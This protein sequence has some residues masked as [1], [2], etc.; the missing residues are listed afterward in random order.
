M[1]EAAAQ[2]AM[3]FNGRL[4]TVYRQDLSFFGIRERLTPNSAI[5][6]VVIYVLMMHRMALQFVA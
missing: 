3:K 2:Y 5:K 4:I 1:K 6:F